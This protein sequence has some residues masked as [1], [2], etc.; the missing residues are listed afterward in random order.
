M[1]AQSTKSLLGKKLV[2]LAIRKIDHWAIEQLN[3]IRYRSGFP[4]CLQISN[5]HWIVG[6]YELKKVS[7]HR[8]NL[9]M[10]GEQVHTFYSKQSAMFYAVFNS[11][12]YYKTGDNIL[13]NDAQVLKYSDDVDLFKFKLYKRKLDSFKYDLYVNRLSEA[14]NRLLSAREELTK[15]IQSAKYMKVW[16]NIL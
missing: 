10:N 8:F 9:F 6:H 7:E 13:K 16:D 2:D 12:G 4:V 11:Q 14:E 3:D 1:A 5:A 15:T